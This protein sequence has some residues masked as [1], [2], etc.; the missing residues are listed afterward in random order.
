MNL[1]DTTITDEQKRE[2]ALSRAYEMK[3]KQDAETAALGR[4]FIW[5]DRFAREPVHL[6]HL[7]GE[8]RRTRNVIRVLNDRG[9]GSPKGELDP[10]TFPFRQQ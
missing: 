1:V 8:G 10:E 9:G 5:G 6:F 7:R 3:T 4:M 2:E